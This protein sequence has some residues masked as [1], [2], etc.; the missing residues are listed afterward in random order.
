M[1]VE[2]KKVYT[3]IIGM[4]DGCT[5]H[6]PDGLIIKQPE[7]PYFPFFKNNRYSLVDVDIWGKIY[8][9]EI[10]KEAVNLLGKERYSIYNAFNEDQ[11]AL[12]AICMVSKSYKYVRK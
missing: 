4:R 1:E 3:N 9:N 5:T 12:F 6:Q 10:Y 8:R 2:I 11:I 7:L